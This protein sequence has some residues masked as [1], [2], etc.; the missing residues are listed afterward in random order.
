MLVIFQG[1]AAMPLKITFT[2]GDRDLKY[3]RVQMGKARLAAKEA[4]DEAII[5]AASELLER[6]SSVEAPEFVHERLGKL[7]V[8]I[9]MVDDARW[10]IPRDVRG[11]VLGAL[12]YFVHPHD[13]I[14]DD[15]P[16]LGFL[17]DA[18]M[19]ELIVRE[20]RHDIEAYEDF[21]R[22]GRVDLEH[23][24]RSEESIVDSRQFLATRDRL[25]RR[26]RR[27]SKRDRERRAPGARLW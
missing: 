25:R 24:S 21:C 20:L 22:E 2:I 19:A 16:V 7:N 17:D 27:R 26:A 5:E 6:V 8:L 9:A 14:P 13:M 3:F 4:G 12:A 18:I 15:V 11:R 23:P 1:E 10:A